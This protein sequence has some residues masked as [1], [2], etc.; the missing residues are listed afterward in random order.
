MLL[1]L[2]GNK[3]K[4]DLCGTL[5]NKKQELTQSCTDLPAEAAAQAG[6]TQSHTKTKR[7]GIK[8]IY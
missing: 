8:D 6:K 2:T 5:C 1:S 7:E 3:L 4:P